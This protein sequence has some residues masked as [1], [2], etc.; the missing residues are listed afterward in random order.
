MIGAIPIGIGKFS[1][2]TLHDILE[3]CFNYND[4][5]TFVDCRCVS[6]STLMREYFQISMKRQQEH[7]TRQ[8]YVTPHFTF[9]QY[10]NLKNEK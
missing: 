7:P 10:S 4:E 8:G 2:P 1:V 3:L 6:V 9:M 5:N